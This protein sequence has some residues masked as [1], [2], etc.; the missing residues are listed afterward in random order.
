MSA[1]QYVMYGMTRYATAKHPLYSVWKNAV[2]CHGVTD[3]WKDF[4]TFAREV[5]K[6]P[7]RTK[8]KPLDPS[9]P[10]GTGNW[11]WRPL[12]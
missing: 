11:H 6:Q 9:Q 10:L 5:G 4:D 3:K 7:H 12:K 1:K 8:L 2:H